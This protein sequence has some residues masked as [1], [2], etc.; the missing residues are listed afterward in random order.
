M[1]R[2]EDVVHVVLC[3]FISRMMCVL[4]SSLS[5]ISIGAILKRWNCGTLVFPFQYRNKQCHKRTHRF[6]RV[7]TTSLQSNLYIA[8]EKLTQYRFFHSMTIFS[9]EHCITYA[10]AS[11]WYTPPPPSSPPST[12]VTLK[13]F[14]GRPHAY[15]VKHACDEKLILVLYC[16]LH[17]H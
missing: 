3:V 16:F 2:S 4:H 13:L 10:S 9:L 12:S 8:S 5:F 1:C 17:R 11:K 7:A 14:A 6:F 15:F